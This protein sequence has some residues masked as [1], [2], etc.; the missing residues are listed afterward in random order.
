MSR[1]TALTYFREIGG[2]VGRFAYA[3]EAASWMQQ[4]NDPWK[5]LCWSGCAGCGRRRKRGMSARPLRAT[6]NAG[7]ATANFGAG[8]LDVHVTGQASPEPLKGPMRI[9]RTTR[10]SRVHPNAT[11]TAHA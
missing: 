5:V 10:A 6:S 2:G 7:S 9:I 8:E 11:H 4:S 3:H 1:R